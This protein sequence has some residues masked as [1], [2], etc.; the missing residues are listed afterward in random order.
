MIAEIIKTVRENKRLLGAPA[1]Y[2][3]ERLTTSIVNF[4]VFTIFVKIYSPSEIGL[5]SYAFAVI[6]LAAP[7]LAGGAEAVVT[8]DLVKNPSRSSEI[9]GSAAFVV[10][11]TTIVALLLPLAYLFIFHSTEQNVLIIA[12]L[13]ATS[14]VPNFLFVIEHAFKAAARPVPPTTA[15]L[16]TTV[17]SNSTKLI[18]ASS[19]FP[20]T[21]VAVVAPFETLIQIS[22]LLYFAKKLAPSYLNWTLSKSMVIDLYRACGPA[23]LAGVVITLQFRINYL[24]ISHLANYREVGFYALAFNIVQLFSSIPGLALAGIYP[25]LVRLS[26]RDHARFDRIMGLLFWAGGLFSGAVVAC[27]WILERELVPRFFGNKYSGADACIVV[28]LFSLAVLTSGAV[29][30]TIINVYNKQNY[31]FWS[32]ALG[33]VILFPI[34]ALLIPYF[35]AEGAAFGL[36]ISTLASGVF[37]TF[38]FPDIRRYAWR[39]ISGLLL[40]PPLKR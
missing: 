28:T 32:A 29:R 25:L 14:F 13:G 9:L 40:I 11:T 39:Q 35:G 16:I 34:S 6:Q 18:I 10:F 31:H 26:V 36:L 23:M 17:A 15:R 12:V 37:S 30:G 19:G 2:V 21:A 7:F 27:G 20:L 4:L 38:V 24:L 33:V 22:L 8:R 5:W 3:G 1:L